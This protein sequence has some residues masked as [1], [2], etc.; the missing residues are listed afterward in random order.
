MIIIYKKPDYFSKYGKHFNE[1]LCKYAISLMEHHKQ[2][3]NKEQINRILNNKIPE[4]N[5]LWDYVFV[6]NMAYNDFYNSSI[7]D[8]RHLALYIKDYIDDED[9]YEGL[10]FCRWYADIKAKNINV[11]LNDMI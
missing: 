1:K 7:E 2:P 10:P 8:E 11:D 9:G 4:N 6:A 5:K 3:L